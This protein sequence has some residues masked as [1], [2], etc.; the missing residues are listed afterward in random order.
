MTLTAA[1]REEYAEVV[2]P[3]MKWLSENCH[4]HTHVVVEST[5]AELVEGVHIFRTNAFLRD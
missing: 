3:L 1:Q 2:K 5:Y 4:P